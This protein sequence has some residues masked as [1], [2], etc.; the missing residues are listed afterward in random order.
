MTWRTHALPTTLTPS[1]M[2]SM[3]TALTVRCACVDVAT[4]AYLPHLLPQI[5][6]GSMAFSFYKDEHGHRRS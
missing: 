4:K 3:C 2:P 6:A 1:R 5:S